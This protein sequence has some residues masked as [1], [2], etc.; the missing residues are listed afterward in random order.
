ML[1][2]TARPDSSGKSR[3]AGKTFLQTLFFF[4]L[5]TQIC[6]TQGTWTKVGDMPEI[7][8]AHTVQHSRTGS[9]TFGQVY[10]IGGVNTEQGTYPTTILV[11]NKPDST[12]DSIPLPGNSLRGQHASCYV[13]K[14]VGR[15]ELWLIGG[16]VMVGGNVNSTAQVNVFNIESNQWYSKNPMP[17][18]RLNLA[19]ALLDNKIYVAGGMH[20]I[21]GVPNY[22]GLETFEVYD[23]LTET[24]SI[25]PNMPTKRWGLS[26]TVFDGQIYVFGGRGLVD[27]PASVDVYDPQTNSWSS[28]ANMPTPRYQLITCLADNKIY[29]IGGWYSSSSGP[30]YNRV[31]VYEPINDVWTTETA[32]P[33]AVAMLNGY[34]LYGK[35]YIYGGTYTTHPCIGTSDIYEFTPSPVSVEPEAT[36]PLEFI[37]QQNY[38]NSFNPDTKIKY[39]VPQTSQVQIKVFDVLGNEVEILVNEEKS[40]GTYEVEFNAAALSGSVSAKGG[41]ASGVYFYQLKAGGFVSTKKM[42]LLK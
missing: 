28:K 25:L 11:Y 23:L 31:E 29:A 32:M 41:Y 10:I 1:S 42:I 33:I 30:I 8:Y 17:T 15:D 3:L 38:P 36:A 39:S 9:E 22:N 13:A 40:V 21:N 7:R 4:L 18:D 24:W 12:W 37:L 35:V 16:G 19:C 2:S 20:C 26:I 6:F 5:V 34:E 14:F 27:R